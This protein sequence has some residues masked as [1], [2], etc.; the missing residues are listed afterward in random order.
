[1]RIKGFSTSGRGSFNGILHA[2]YTMVC[3]LSILLCAVQI[4]L[5]TLQQIQNML[6]GFTVQ[7]LV[8]VLTWVFYKRPHSLH[9]APA[10]R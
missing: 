6:N 2:L 7:P 1:M 10:E 5:I 3:A 8:Q 9:P 4:L